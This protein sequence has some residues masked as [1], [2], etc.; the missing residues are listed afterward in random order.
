MDAETAQPVGSPT[1]NEQPL[2]SGDLVLFLGSR[3]AQNRGI[4]H[5]GMLSTASASFT[6]VQTPV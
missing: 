4:T 2:V 5:V 1:L 3:D 6:P